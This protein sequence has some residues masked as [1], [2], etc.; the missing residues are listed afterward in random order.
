MSRA[1]VGRRSLFKDVGLEREGLWM[2]SLKD[3]ERTII[4]IY[5]YIYIWYMI[6]EIVKY[7]HWIL[8]L[9]CF[10]IIMLR[11][12]DYNCYLWIVHYIL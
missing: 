9:N 1:S 3:I 7:M 4:Y 5:I 10:D 2:E 8:G 6:C 12:Y 11:S